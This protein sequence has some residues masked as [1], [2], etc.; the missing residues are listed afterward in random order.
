MNRQQDRVAQYNTIE[1]CLIPRLLWTH[2][3]VHTL[4]WLP[5]QHSALSSQKPQLDPTVTKWRYSQIANTHMRHPIYTVTGV[6]RKWGLLSHATNAVRC[7]HVI[8][9]HD[10]L[11]EVRG[12]KA[13]S[14]HTRLVQSMQ[15]WTGARDHPDSVSRS[16]QPGQPPSCVWHC[17]PPA[18]A[19]DLQTAVWGG[20][21]CHHG[22]QLER[23]VTPVLYNKKWVRQAN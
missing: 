3:C 5:L 2:A 22:N 12:E 21:H 6:T 20:C 19:W 16:S 4:D 10:S 17:S 11:S 23:Q 9:L 8:S 15:L 1:T 13:L 14:L 18:S 7:I